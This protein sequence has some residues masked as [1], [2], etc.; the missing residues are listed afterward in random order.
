MSKMMTRVLGLWC[1]FPLYLLPFFLFLSLPT[2]SRSQSSIA[3]VYLLIPK[4]ELTTFFSVSV[5]KFP[6]KDWLT[7][8][9]RI[10]QHSPTNIIWSEDDSYRNHATMWY[11]EE[12]FYRNHVDELGRRRDKAPLVSLIFMLPFFRKSLF[13]L[14][15]VSACQN[16]MSFK[17]QLKCH[18]FHQMS[19]SASRPRILKNRK[20]ISYSLL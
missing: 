7:C 9:V 20:Y 15:S 1:F 13:L 11:Q 10:H 4:K 6:R 14:F 16:C 8:Q 18:L 5:P 19:A 3:K 17:V 2:F 12:N